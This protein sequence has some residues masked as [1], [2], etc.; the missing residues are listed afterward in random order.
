LA[1]QHVSSDIIAHHQELLNRN[2]SFWFYS[3]LS[4]LAAVMA[5]WALNHDSGQQ[6]QTCVKPDAVI[7]V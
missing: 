6:R 3:R 1:A 2:Y 5:E 7:T 4:L